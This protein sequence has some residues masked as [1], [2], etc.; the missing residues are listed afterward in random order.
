M[1]CSKN[2][3]TASIF[4]IHVKKGGWLITAGERLTQSAKAYIEAHCE[5]K[6]SL[7]VIS[8]ALFVNG[9]YLLRTFKA[10]TGQTLLSYHNV[11]RCEKAKKLLL[12]SEC[13]VSEAGEEAG[14]SSSAHFSHVFKKVTG[15]TPT[16]YR[17]S[18]VQSLVLEY[19]ME[20]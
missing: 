12:G 8:N 10:H 16:Q 14:F 9:S 19:G 4:Y 7:Q 13:T 15:M 3:L 20:E 5:E 6:F 17:K 2:I 1:P 18:E 11:M